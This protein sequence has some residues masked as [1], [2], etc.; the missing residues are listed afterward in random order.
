MLD[1]ANNKSAPRSSL[2]EHGNRK[3]RCAICE[4]ERSRQRRQRFAE[5]YRYRNGIEGPEGEVS[6]SRDRTYYLR[7]KYGLTEERVRELLGAQ[8]WRCQICALPLRL[9]G[10]R[11]TMAHVDHDHQTGAVR[12]IL[13]RHCNTAL[14]Y[15]RNDPDRARRAAAYLER[16]R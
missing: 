8:G 2:C 10:P 12:G 14:G 13:C 16:D 7:R 15:L 11:A 5:N 4:Q 1:N 9:A 3:Y 6:L